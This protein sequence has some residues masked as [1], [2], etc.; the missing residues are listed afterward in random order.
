MPRTKRGTPSPY[1]NIPPLQPLLSICIIIRR[2]PTF[3]CKYN[4]LYYY[5]NIIYIY[6]LHDGLRPA[7]GLE[8]SRRSHR[9]R[10][11]LA[12][13][14]RYRINHHNVQLS[15]LRAIWRVPTE[16]GGGSHLYVRSV[17]GSRRRRVIIIIIILMQRAWQSARGQAS[18]LMT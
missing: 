3:V 15:R 4:I 2:Y 8:N 11:S 9:D 16:R 12:Y 18:F 13:G 5:Y 6:S 7:F 10:S 1:K 14:I 17:R